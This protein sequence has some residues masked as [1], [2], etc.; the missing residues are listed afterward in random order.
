YY[1]N[2]TAILQQGVM[3]NGDFFDERHGLD[4]LQN[5]VQTN[6]YNLLYTSTTTIPQTD[7]GVTR[8]LS[9]V[10]Q[11][12]DQSVTNGLVAAGVWNGGPIG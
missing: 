12:M 5:Y 8:L 11:S 3:A 6:L 2:D 9:N 7:A 10:E 1:A 4:W